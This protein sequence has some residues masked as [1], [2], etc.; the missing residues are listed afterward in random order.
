MNF[1]EIANA[2]RQRQFLVSKPIR[3]I[4]PIDLQRNPEIIASR[5]YNGNF[6][7]AVVDKDDVRF[8]TASHLPLTTLAGS[9][10]WQSGEW[11]DALTDT[12]PG[13][14]FLGEIFIPNK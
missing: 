13:T 4:R 6:A 12:A 3:E 2:I 11:K 9:R 14:I 5:K 1:E 10:H 8:Y 7:T